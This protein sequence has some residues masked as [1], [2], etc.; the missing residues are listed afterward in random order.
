MKFEH[1]YTR[2]PYR[3]IIRDGEMPERP[4]RTYQVRGV[5]L[6]DLRSSECLRED[7]AAAEDLAKKQAHIDAR[8]V[9]FEDTSRLLNHSPTGCS[10]AFLANGAVG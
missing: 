8:P 10:L 2:R 9:L 5:T 3:T 7:A 6:V 4:V 1:L